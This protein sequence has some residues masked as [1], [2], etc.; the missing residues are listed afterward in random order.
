[1]GSAMEK[2]KAV[3]VEVLM[4]SFRSVVAIVPKDEKEKRQLVEDLTQIECKGLLV[5]SW[6]LKNEDMA[7]EFSQE[8]SNK[9][10]GTI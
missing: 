7:R 8:H 2:N 6:G 10:E 5:Q 3:K 4:V 1:M 9:W